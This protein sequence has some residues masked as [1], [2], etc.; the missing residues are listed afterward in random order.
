M[1][2][3]IIFLLCLF[4]LIRNQEINAQQEN[5]T[6]FN[7]LIQKCFELFEPHADLT[8]SFGSDELR[9]E[10]P[11]LTSLPAKLQ[12]TSLYKRELKGN[13]KDWLTFYKIGNLCQ[14]FQLHEQAMNYYNQAYSLIYNEITKDTLKAEP[15]SQMGT[16]YLNL[17][18]N[19]NAYYFF[20]KAYGR[21]EK[22]S[23]ASIFLPMFY[24]FNGNHTKAEELITNR[25]SWD[26]QNIEMHI[27]LLTAKIF[28]GI[29]PS[30]QN[31]EELR[32]KSIDQIFDLTSLKKATKKF[33]KDIRF[34]L[35]NQLG[36]QMALLAKYTS[37]SD[38]F[39]KLSLTL[40]DL[41]E[42][43][44]IRKELNK[45]GDKNLFKNKYIINK[46]LGFNYLME[47]NHHIAIMHFRK[48]ISQWPAEK[49]SRDYY[50][51][52]T[53]HLFLQNDT[54]SALKILDEKIKADGENAVP[55]PEDYV[56]KGKIFLQKRD[57]NSAMESFNQANKIKPTPEAYLGL[58]LP[59]ILSGDLMAAN[60]FINQ[61][62]ELNR[63]FYLTYSLFGIITRINNQLEPSKNAFGQALKYKPD[64][65]IIKEILEIAF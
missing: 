62:Y 58:S 12:D 10:I 54:L 40:P 33:P 49:V 51:I 27:W 21:N 14:K 64:E 13:Y 37:I 19:D 34:A 35:L 55:L 46:S 25:L 7:Y 17:K 22:D 2:K 5:D 42:L 48:A 41:D 29:K 16:L 32:A 3:L 36:R 24:I 52:F 38:E 8:F 45:L 23:A 61:A 57:F 59:H 56:L 15:L 26:P 20:Q 4:G 31:T 6:L 18:S 43:K 47:N 39:D 65:K 28:Q 50:L 11:V 53:T 9:N 1:N 30:G 63:E 60:K 44:T